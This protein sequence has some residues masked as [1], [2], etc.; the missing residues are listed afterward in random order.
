MESCRQLQL[1]GQRRFRTGFP[2]H[3]NHAWLTVEDQQVN[4][5]RAS[6]ELKRARYRINLAACGSGASRPLEPTYLRLAC[7]FA[8]KL[9]GAA[10]SLT[11]DHGVKCARFSQNILVDKPCDEILKHELIATRP[12]DLRLEW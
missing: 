6:L 7:F 10:L 9:N 12:I 5:N 3:L 11:F 1:R 8:S 2:F 4:R